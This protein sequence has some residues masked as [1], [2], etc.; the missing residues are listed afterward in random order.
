M[1]KPWVLAT[2]LAPLGLMEIL[3]SAPS[4]PLTSMAR[5]RSLSL[6]KHNLANVRI[7]SRTGVDGEDLDGVGPSRRSRACSSKKKQLNARQ[8]M[9]NKFV[10]QMKKKE[11]T[12]MQEARALGEKQIKND[13]A[14]RQ[15][16]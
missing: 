6:V 1:K 12:D 5:R 13:E 7:F 11:T 16:K 14:G 9:H 10:G 8:F 2:I 4:V 15:A 3:V